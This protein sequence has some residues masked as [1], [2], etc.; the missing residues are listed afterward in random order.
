MENPWVLTG[1]SLSSVP[2]R[3]HAWRE[4]STEL[5]CAAWPCCLARLCSIIGRE[6]DGEAP[7]SVWL[8]GSWSQVSLLVEWNQNIQCID[9]DRHTYYAEV[10][11]YSF[12]SLNVC[13][14]THTHTYIHVNRNTYIYILHTYLDRFI[15]HW[16]FSPQGLLDA[17]FLYFPQKPCPTPGFK[18]N[19]WGTSALCE[20]SA[21]RI[22]RLWALPHW[23]FSHWWYVLGSPV[24]YFWRLSS[25]WDSFKSL[26]F[27]RRHFR[28]LQWQLGALRVPLAKDLEGFFR[29][30]CGFQTLHHFMFPLIVVSGSLWLIHFP[31]F[32]EFPACWKLVIWM[33]VKIECI[34]YRWEQDIHCRNSKLPM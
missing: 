27:E 12:S 17:T 25:G 21:M 33:D 22:Q 30:W 13:I 34:L 5:Q 23:W 32:L 14:Y 18:Q 1:W 19:S 2:W 24:I 10:F 29:G 9:N 7:T 6:A 15:T 3:L 16:V 20:R 28:G 8:E 11:D 31:L 4:L 26:D